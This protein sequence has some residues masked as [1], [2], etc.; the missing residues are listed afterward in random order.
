MNWV[1][2]IAILVVLLFVWLSRDIKKKRKEWTKILGYEPDDSELHTIIK[3]SGTSSQEEIIETIKN[4]KKPS[5]CTSSTNI[6]CKNDAIEAELIDDEYPPETPM[7]LID[8]YERR[9]FDAMRFALQ[10]VA[11]EMVGDRYTQQ[12]KD[13]FKKIMTF[14]AYKDP[15]YNDLIKRILPIISKNEGMLQTQI[16]PYFK[17]Y[18]VEML[19]Y[20]LYFGNELDDIYRVKSGRSYKLYTSNPCKIKETIQIN[21]D[22]NLEVEATLNIETGLIQKN[23][24]DYIFEEIETLYFKSLK[25]CIYS[26]FL[27][28]DKFKKAQYFTIK[29]LDIDTVNTIYKG[30]FIDK[31]YYK[32]LD[33][34]KRKYIKQFGYNSSSLSNIERH[35]TNVAYNIALYTFQK[36]NS[37]GDFWYFQVGDDRNP[38][39]KANKKYL[40]QNDAFFDIY[41]PPNFFGDNSQVRSITKDILDFDKKRYGKF[42]SSMKLYVEDDFSFNIAKYFIESV[43]DKKDIEGI[44]QKIKKSDSELY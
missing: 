40:V 43:F 30:Y 3:M 20:V 37:S 1:I 29:D 42:R 14:F 21:I 5:I 7:E 17:E 41:Y 27:Q 8:F 22:K 24:T 36:T 25:T 44:M 19:R 16:Y 38:N 28:F 34:E 32:A 10:K 12:E 26:D 6:E 33:A 15:L 35:Y 4:V 31:T 11:Y 2:T 18:D 39:S 23:D 9:E 13:K